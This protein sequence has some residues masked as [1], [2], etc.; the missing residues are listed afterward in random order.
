MWLSASG[1]RLMVVSIVLLF[2]VSACS[3]G[4]DGSK[5]ADAHG[6]GETLIKPGDVAG[7]GD[8][9]ETTQ[10][11]PSLECQSNAE[12]P[13]A[14]E[15]CDCTGS[16]VSG[17]FKECDEDKNCGG[18]NY[19]DPCVKGCFEKN[20]LCGECRSEHLCNPVT[21]ECLPTGN[22]CDVEGSLCMDFV[23]GGSYCGQACLSDAGCPPGFTCEDLTEYGIEVNQCLPKTGNCSA[24][25][26]CE[27]D[28]DCEFG[29]VC[30]TDKTCSLGCQ[31]DTECP[32]GMVCSAFRCQQACDGVNNPCPEGQECD[33]TGH[34]KIPGGCIDAYD[35]LEPETYCDMD[36]H[37]CTPGCQ[38]DIDCKSSAKICENEVCEAKGCTAN[39][40]CSFGQVC[41]LDTGECVEPE[42]PFCEPGC[43]EDA[44][45]G[46]EP[47]K[48]L[49]LQDEDGN[50]KGAFCFPKCYD[51]P[52]NL[53]PQ[54]YQCME[55]TDQDG[56]SMGKVCARTCY[57]TPVG[58]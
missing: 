8:A 42:E 5:S 41:A 23:T 40:W 53:C 50:D 25:T 55:L 45:C 32:T 28:M 27:K 21:G 16:C 31:H 22:Q 12:C 52:E 26:E 29:Y 13:A 38:H 58:F 56:A 24:V 49:N 3:G 36:T 19:C 44:E 46:P 39:Y 54:G 34:C 51:D 43:Q 30:N 9:V 4:S 35:C 37:L 17:G 10:P 11:P 2:G 18:G 1:V 7:P 14:G 15:V 20:T 6:T 47:S 57:E 33:D 48:C